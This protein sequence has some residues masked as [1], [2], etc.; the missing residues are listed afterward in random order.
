MPLYQSKHPNDACTKLSNIFHKSHRV[1]GALLLRCIGIGCSRMPL[2]GCTQMDADMSGLLQRMLAKLDD[3]HLAACIAHSTFGLIPP[4]HEAAVAKCDFLNQN[5]QSMHFD[6]FQHSGKIISG[7]CTKS[8][9]VHGALLL[10]CIGV[11]CSPMPL[12]GCTQMDADRSGLLQRMLAKLDD[13][14]LAACIAHSTFGLT[15]P[16]HEA[17]IAK[18]DFLNPNTTSTH[19]NTFQLTGKIISGGCTELCCSDALGS[20]AIEWLALGCT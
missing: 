16:P 5:T 9:R 3:T 7:G 1:H 15:P 8:Y 20:D 6:T 12:V 10:G 11:G 19:F 17:A 14:H 18:C 13:T 2:V 4:P